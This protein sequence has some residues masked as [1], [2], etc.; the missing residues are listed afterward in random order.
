MEIEIK[1]RKWKY[2]AL[3]LINGNKFSHT[4][5]KCAGAIETKRWTGTLGET[6]REEDRGTLE[7][8]SIAESDRAGKSWNEIK[9]LAAD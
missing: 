4:L 5:R 6:A 1:K 3:I 8:V 2:C 7:D 9:A